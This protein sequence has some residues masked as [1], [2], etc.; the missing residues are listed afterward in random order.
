MIKNVIFDLGN[1]VLQLHFEDVIKKFTD[2]KSEQELL[3]KVIFCSDEWRKLDAGY[4]TKD[5]AIKVMKSNLPDSLHKTCDD[6]MSSWTNGFIINEDTIDFIKK[7][8]E[9]GY[10]RY[11]LSNAPLELRGYLEKHDLLSLF[12]GEILSAEYKQEKPLEP[13]Y[14]TLFK[15][16]DL[17]PEECLFIDDKKENIDSA[18]KLGMNGYVFNYNDFGSFK[19]FIKKYDINV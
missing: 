17:I 2:D 3:N 13:I 10:N 18:I 4:I 12:D 8:K 5:E 9:K 14:Q 7:I 1:V 11:I 15:T 19:D 6:I 16:Y